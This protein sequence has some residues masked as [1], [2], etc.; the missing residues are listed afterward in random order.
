M[1]S[2][3]SADKQTGHDDVME[4]KNKAL[5][6]N[7]AATQAEKMKGRFNLVINKKLPQQT[8]INRFSSEPIAFHLYKSR[9]FFEKLEKHQQ[10]TTTDKGKDNI[11]KL[12]KKAEDAE[13]LVEE[14]QQLR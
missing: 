6:V 12:R 7:E 13:K 3:F 4:I 1:R 8:Q 10:E 5:L 14:A 2:E 9:F 11:Q